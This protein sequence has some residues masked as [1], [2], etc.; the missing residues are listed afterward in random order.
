MPDYTILVRAEIAKRCFLAEALYWRAF[1]RIPVEIYGVNG[2]WRDDI[3]IH[4]GLETSMPEGEELS[5][6]ECHYAGLTLDPRMQAILTG[7]PDLPIEFYHQ[8][9]EDSPNS[10][11]KQRAELKKKR[12]ELVEAERY[13]AEVAQWMPQ[14][15]D[16]ID[17]FK[18]EICV[19]LRRGKLRAVGRKLPCPSADASIDQ[20]DKK[21]L[22]LDSLEVGPVPETAWLTRDVNWIDSTIFGNHASYIWIEVSVSEL[23]EL[24]PPDRLLKPE[25]VF[26]VGSSVA[27]SGILAAAKTLNTRRGRPSLPWDDFHVEVARLYREAQMPEKKEAAIAMLQEWF[28]K[29]T[30]KVVSRSSIG[31]KLKPYF[32]QLGRKS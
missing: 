27:V 11:R 13:H 12:E 5:D 16:Y 9:I 4:E 30:G 19:D 3:E 29:A 15:E 18:A 6:D 8:L 23:L 25:Q 14:F 28:E 22:W 31:A 20:L 1:G 32:D 17:Q 10:D 7:R 24:Y 2:P 26:P 21:D